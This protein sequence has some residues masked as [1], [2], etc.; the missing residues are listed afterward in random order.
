VPQPTPQPPQQ[1]GTIDRAAETLFADDLQQAVRDAR[2][3]AIREAAQ[4]PAVAAAGADQQGARRTADGLLAAARALLQPANPRVA[5]VSSALEK[6]EQALAAVPNDA[7]ALALET[8]ANETLARLRDAAKIDA[9]IRNARSRF[10]IGKHQAAIQLLEGLDPASHP[11]VAEALQE[12]RAALQAIEDRRRGAE[13]ARQP[14][15]AP[16]TDATRVIL[17]PEILA[18]MQQEARPTPTPAPA[19][20]AQKMPTLITAPAETPA[21]APADADSRRRLM[22]F[23]G[24]LLLLFVIALVLLRFAP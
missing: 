8:T 5:D 11:A 19:A 18:Q 20:D 9:A 14:L 1:A 15:P 3:A 17:M 21:A 23:G 12:L 2:D 6:I 16:D 4:P 10:A 24:A 13:A 22:I 7:E